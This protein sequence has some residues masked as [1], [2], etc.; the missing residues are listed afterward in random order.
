MSPSP[1]G[2]VQ[3]Q[4]RGG[5]SCLYRDGGGDQT[6]E[7]RAAAGDRPWGGDR[8]GGG[9]DEG[10]AAGDGGGQSGPAAGEGQ[11]ML[12]TPFPRGRTSPPRR[13]RP[14]PRCCCRT[15]SITGPG[16]KAG[17]SRRSSPPGPVTGGNKS[18]VL[19]PSAVVISESGSPKRFVKDGKAQGG[20]WE[21]AGTQ[22]HF[23]V[24][25]VVKAAASFQSSH[26][27]Q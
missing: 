22:G 12:N 25:R 18:D 1:G 8:H 11:A 26:S 14:S 16:R 10:R 15:G 5:R 17:S 2:E 24:R 20:K 4:N 27:H 7:T 6:G 13:R 9:G 21:I 23:R 3:R 19:G